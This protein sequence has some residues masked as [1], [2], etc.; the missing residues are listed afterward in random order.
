MKNIRKYEGETFA[1]LTYKAVGGFTLIEKKVK[2]ENVL[3]KMDTTYDVVKNDA[4]ITGTCVICVLSSTL[5]DLL[6]ENHFYNQDNR[7]LLQY[8]SV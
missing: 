5:D 3:Q 2:P 4:T 8:G 6:E 1:V 7:I